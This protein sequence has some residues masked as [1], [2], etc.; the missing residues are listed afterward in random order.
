MM[1]MSKHEMMNTT[2]NAVI[3]DQNPVWLPKKS[4]VQRRNDMNL[5]EYS[6]GG[7]RRS[8]AIDDSALAIKHAEEENFDYKDFN[9][10]V[11]KQKS[12]TSA[13]NQK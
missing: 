10:I 12:F 6:G 1:N 4:L 8:Q 7:G 11:G 5:T 2:K 3:S 9:F 13:Q